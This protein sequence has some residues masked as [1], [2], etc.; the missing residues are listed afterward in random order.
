MKK[1]SIIPFFIIV[2]CM[3]FGCVT[4][5]RYIP[6]EKWDLGTKVQGYK[7]TKLS[8]NQFQVSFTANHTTADQTAYSYC[9]YRCAE[10]TKENGFDY[11]IITSEKDISKHVAVGTVGRYVVTAEE[12][13]MPTYNVRIKC[14]KGIKPNT[15]NAFYASDIIKTIGP[16]IRR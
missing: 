11:F 8:S 12:Q 9:L 3:F 10:V 15:D 6:E 2:I 13:R 16:T 7:D 4:P 1:R 5:T 14:G